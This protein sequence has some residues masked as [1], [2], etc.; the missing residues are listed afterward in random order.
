[1]A[2]KTSSVKSA[3]S[4][5]SRTSSSDDT[6]L[7]AADSKRQTNIFLDVG[8]EHIRMRSRWW[9]IWYF[10]NTNEEFMLI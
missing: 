3:T 10:I 8:E 2:E 9:Q 1:M 6:I 4:E 7:A 5:K